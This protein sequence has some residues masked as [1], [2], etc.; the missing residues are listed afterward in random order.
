MLHIILLI[1][2]IIGFLILGVLALGL[3][4]TAVI[5]LAPFVYRLECSVDNSLESVKGRIRFH[6][7]MH[8]I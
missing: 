7:L 1:L 5:L 8:L 2:K 3:L 6:W 4:L